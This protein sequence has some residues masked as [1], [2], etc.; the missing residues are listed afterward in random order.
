M[1]D[2]NNKG[3]DE[4]STEE[5]SYGEDKTANYSVKTT[6]SVKARL[7][8]LAEQTNLTQKDLFSTM[9]ELLEIKVSTEVFSDFT[10]DIEEFKT[11]TER[12]FRS[13]VHTIERS[14]AI[15][16]NENKNSLFKIE[17]KEEEIQKLQEQ[18]NSFKQQSA[19]MK[20][21]KEQIEATNNELTLKLQDNHKNLENVQL[22]TDE[23]KSKNDFLTAQLLKFEQYESQNIELKEQISTITETANQEKVALERSVNDLKR[24]IEELE[25]VIAFEEKQKPL[26]IKEAVLNTK[27]E[28]QE[29]IAENNRKHQDSIN[30]YLKKIEQLRDTNELALSKQEEVFEKER[31]ANEIALEKQ[32]KLFAKERGAY[33]AKIKALETKLTE[34]DEKNSKKSS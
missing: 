8:N 23:Y 2:L 10:L 28:L 4:E 21:I 6:D 29:Q 34:K 20:A 27:A 5:I 24:Q 11:N 14:S 19:E 7:A 32:E 22:L 16:E 1:D 12:L 3:L 18:L 26:E 15:R 25:Q 17:E 30:E 31:N 13:F 9:V 33:E